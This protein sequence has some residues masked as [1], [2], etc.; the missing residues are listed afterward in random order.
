MPTPTSAPVLARRLFP[1]ALMACALGAS[2]CAGCSSAVDAPE[3]AAPPAHRGPDTQLPS[4]HDRPASSASVSVSDDEVRRDVIELLTLMSRRL[5][6]MHDVARWKWNAQRPVEDAERETALLARLERAAAK[7][8]IERSFARRF[9]LDQIE[10]AKQI[11]QTAFEHWRAEGIVTHDV[12]RDLAS[13]LR[14]EIDRVSD[15]LLDSLARLE[16][17]RQ[18][19][20]VAPVAQSLAASNLAGPEITDEVRTTALHSLTAAGD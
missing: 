10:A 4:P 5:E 8:G 18:D 1:A 17:A 6:L 12:V 13:D 7:R 15:S 11:Q 2:M 19:R 3:P 9:F 20:L 14:P 16:P